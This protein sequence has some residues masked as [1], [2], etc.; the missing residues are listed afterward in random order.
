MK[1]GLELHPDKTC[2]IEFGR[3]AAGNRKERG[4]GK[5]ETFNFLGFTHICGRSRKGG[6]RVERRTIAKR[7]R[8]KLGE[9]KAE[10]KHRFHDP[11][12]ELGAWLRSVLVG[13]YRYYGVPLNYDALRRF[14]KQVVRLW[15]RALSR[16][17]Q[18][19]QVNWSRMARLA[20]RWLPKPRI[21][22]PYPNQ[23]L[24]VITRGRSPVR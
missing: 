15:K 21:Y 6:F 14:R 8:S 19:G 16:R 10:L 23:R 4:Q 5:P 9:I 17:S 3:F 7:L 1:F 11:I 22:H 24:D 13:H 12:P 2:L 18:K 20:R